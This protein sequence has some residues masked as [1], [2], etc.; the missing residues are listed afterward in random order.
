[1]KKNVLCTAFIASVTLCGMYFSLLSN[2]KQNSKVQ[3]TN[4]E[5]LSDSENGPTVF[6]CPDGP[7]ECA[8]VI[9]GNTVHIFKMP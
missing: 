9:T 4:I 5:A 1:M 2:Q 3:L 6:E 8:R 7:N